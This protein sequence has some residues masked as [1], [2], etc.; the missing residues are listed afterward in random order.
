MTHL[1]FD[2]MYIRLNYRKMKA[3]TDTPLDPNDLFISAN[4]SVQLNCSK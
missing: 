4:I 1:A 3:T 2:C